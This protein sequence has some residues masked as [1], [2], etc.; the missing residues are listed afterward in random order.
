MYRDYVGFSIKK[1]CDIIMKRSSLSSFDLLWNQDNSI[2]E[3][4]ETSHQLAQFIES[5]HVLE[6][7]KNG[8]L[9]GCG[10][11]IKVHPDWSFCD[12]GVWV[13][14]VY[15]GCSYGAQILIQLREYAL[16]NKFT[17]SCGC[18]I[19]NL[20]SQKVIE[21]SGYVSHFSLLKFKTK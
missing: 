11:V 18:S 5:E 3:L 21:K 19:D 2:T 10:T 6:F 13:N 7:Y 15:R 12:L 4:F 16:N 20:P 14:P 9:I 8:N 17:P 1:E